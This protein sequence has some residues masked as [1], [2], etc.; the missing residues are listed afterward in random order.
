MKK[1][2]MIWEVRGGGIEGLFFWS[3]EGLA[4]NEGGKRFRVAGGSGRG[5]VSGV[6]TRE[7]LFFVG[8]DVVEKGGDMYVNIQQQ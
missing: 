2:K 8:G 5:G 3:K 4:S 1:M 7:I 6:G